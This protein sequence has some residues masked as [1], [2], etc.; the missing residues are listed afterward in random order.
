LDDNQ[1]QVLTIAYHDDRGM[2]ASAA[3]IVPERPPRPPF[4]AFS[5]GDT[6]GERELKKRRLRYVTTSH[7]HHDRD[8]R[9][10]MVFG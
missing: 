3:G 6:P 7:M 2:P 8:S 5:L 9:H 10:S 1:R 4:G